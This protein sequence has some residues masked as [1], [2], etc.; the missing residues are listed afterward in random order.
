VNIP[1]E[2]GVGQWVE[3]H[4]GEFDG[5]KVRVMDIFYKD[6]MRHIAAETQNGRSIEIVTPIEVASE[7][8]VR[9]MPRE[10]GT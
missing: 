8:E 10:M 7:L 9:E 6:G 5:A 3:I 1:I 2:Q 4:G